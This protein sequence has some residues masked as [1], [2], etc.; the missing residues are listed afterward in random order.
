MLLALTDVQVPHGGR[1]SVAGHE[2]LQS[3]V[4]AGLAQVP[5]DVLAD[6]H[7]EVE[8]GAE[9]EVLPDPHDPLYGISG[10]CERLADRGPAHG[11]AAHGPR[12]VGRGGF[13][14]RRCGA[15][16]EKGEAENDR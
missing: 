13:G 9:A 4:A 16:Q 12:P 2:A 10:P 5:C 14:L 11:L 15:T 1:E 3:A 6:A 7:G 8:A